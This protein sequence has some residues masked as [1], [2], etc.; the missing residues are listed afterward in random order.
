M[1][2]SRI[3]VV[4]SSNTDM[5]VR[6]DRLP[7]AGET[8]LGQDLV[9][10]AGGKGANQAVAAARLGAPVTFVAKIGTDMFGDEALANFHREGLDTRFVFREPGVPS[11]VALIVV[12][13]DGQNIITVAPGA[14]NRLSPADIESAREVFAGAAVV[15]LQLETPVETVTAAARMGKANGAT[16]ILNPAPAR[17]LPDELLELVDILTPNETEAE[18][19]TGEKDPTAAARRL[20]DRK[21]N[22]VLITLGKNGALFATGQEPAKIIPGFV[23]K[24]V[25]ATA[26]G[27]AFN[28]ALAVA[29]AE[30]R[31]MDQAIRFSHA[32]AALSVMKLGAQPSL[33]TLNEV[34]RFLPVDI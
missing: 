5:I 6:S 25:D 15:V 33:P 30:G 20:L 19:L 26:A 8:V 32:V 12:G 29:V 10:A 16:V 17:P 1:S 2:A 34:R 11:G 23:V 13:P 14:N 21:L 3:V 9:T 31:N 7:L 28:G 22:T 27:D 18:I 24:A 4:G